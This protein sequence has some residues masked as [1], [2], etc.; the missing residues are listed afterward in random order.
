MSTKKIFSLLNRSIIFSEDSISRYEDNAHVRLGNSYFHQE[1]KDFIFNKRDIQEKFIESPKPDIFQEFK[2][3]VRYDLEKCITSPSSAEA[4][5][6]L[7]K[8]QNLFQ[9]DSLSSSL[10]TLL[11]S[12]MD[13][14][15][16]HLLIIQPD[17]LDIRELRVILTV[18][19]LFSIEERVEIP[20]AL[21]T[22]AVI[23][24]VEGKT[25]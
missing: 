15:F 14:Y 18:M 8:M 19:L 2:L 17:S 23:I 3:L 13:K 5:D 24:K 4:R 1:M 12:E 10:A 7:L 22:L 21:Y 6:C 11:K 9:T 20:E 25:I 16:D